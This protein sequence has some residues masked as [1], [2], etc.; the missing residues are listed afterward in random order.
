MPKTMKKAQQIRTMFP[1]GL[2]EVMRV[3]TTS[4]NPGARLI[5]LKNT[6]VDIQMFFNTSTS[7]P[8]PAHKYK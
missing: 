5:T 8:V 7:N 1:M 2:R 6:N 3:S 4:F